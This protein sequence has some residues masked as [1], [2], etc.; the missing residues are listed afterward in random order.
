M[1][2]VILACVSLQFLNFCLFSAAYVFQGQVCPLEFSVV[3]VSLTAPQWSHSAGSFVF[4]FSGEMVAS[5]KA[6]SNSCLIFIWQECSVGG[7]G[8][9]KPVS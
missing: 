8:V 4:S 7:G 2:L 1:R 9:F 5:A 3:C 6:R